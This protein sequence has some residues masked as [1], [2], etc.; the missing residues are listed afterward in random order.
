MTA[1][2]INFTSGANRLVESWFV[3]VCEIGSLETSDE[4]LRAERETAAFFS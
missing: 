2:A 1:A 4:F 3:K